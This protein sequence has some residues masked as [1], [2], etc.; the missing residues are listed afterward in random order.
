VNDKTRRLT[1]SAL[2]SALTIV[3]LY[4]AS[5]W[6]TGQLGLVAVASLFAAAAVVEAGLVPAIYVF[7]V[8]SI[9]GMLII[10]NRAAPFLYILFFGYYPILKSLIERTRWLALQWALKLL[11]FNVSLSVIWFFLMELIFQPIE[12]LPGIAF[13]YIGGNVIF[14]V[15]DYG[16]SKLIWLYISRV[17]RSG[18]RKN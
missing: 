10:P 11:A 3:I 2:F 17:S 8:S 9:L 15:Y 13:I 4:F 18:N 14:A 12:N 6:P 7:V 1:L 5:I 16:Y